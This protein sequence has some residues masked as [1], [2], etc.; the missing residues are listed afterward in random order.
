M[1]RLAFPDAAIFEREES[2][3]TGTSFSNN[4]DDIPIDPALTGIPLDPALLALGNEVQIEQ[5]SLPIVPIDNPPIRYR[6][7]YSQE[8]PTMATPK[9]PRK[10]RKVAREKECGFCRAKGNTNAIP[11]RLLT[12]AECG[13]SGHPTCL[14]IN[15]LG[16]I[17][18]QYDWH[19]IDCKFCEV[20][21][22]KGDESRL[23]FCDVCDRGWHMDCLEP[24]LEEAPSGDWNCPRCPPREYSQMP[25]GQ[26]YPH[27]AD[28]SQP[29]GSELHEAS[30]SMLREPSVASSS[31]S[32]P[33]AYRKRKGK[34]Q[35][36]TTDDSEMDADGDVE[37]DLDVEETPVPVKT[38]GRAKKARS[39]TR[40]RKEPVED[41]IQEPESSRPL[42][43][44]RLRVS[45]PVPPT[46]PRPPMIRLKLPVRTTKGKER[47]EEPDDAKKGM[48]DDLLDVEDRDVTQ[49]NVSNGDKMRFEKSRAEAEAEAERSLHPP[50][51]PSTTL[52]APETPIAGPSTRPL[53]ST[54]IAPPPP[55]PTPGLSASP[56][57]SNPDLTKLNGASTQRIRSIRFG[58]YDIQTWYDA[59]FPEEYANL[60]DGRL[61]LCEFCLKYMKS[62]FVA[63]RHQMKCKMRHPPGDEIYRDGVISIFEVDG[64]KNKIYCQN[65][66]LLSKMFLDHKSLFYDVEPFLFY[67]MT[68][69]DESAGSR[70][71]GYFS[72]EKRSPKDYNVS[73]IMTLPVRQRQ[74]WGNLLIDFSYL[75]SKKEHRTGS[76]EK[77]LSALGALGYKNYWTLSLMRYLRDAPENPKLEDIANAT[78]MTTED[79]YATLQQ[80]Q[81]IS[82][83]D[84]TPP[85]RPPP[86][87][88]FRF[89]KGKK[90]G[91]A[92]KH[93]VR[94][95][96]QDTDQGLTKGPFVP[97]R[98]YDITWDPSVV[99][100]Y[101]VK[102][103]GKGY[104]KL[105]PECLK[106]SPFL[107]ARTMKSEGLPE[108]G[109]AAATQSEQLETPVEGSIPDLGDLVD[110][111]G[112][113]D[114]TP[115]AGPSSSRAKS[116][117]TPRTRRA[118]G[119]R[120]T[121]ASVAAASPAL[122]LFDEPIREVETPN[123]RADP[124]EEEEEE[125][126]EAR[127]E[128][129]E[130]EEESVGGSPK[131][132]GREN[133]EE[134]EVV[135]RRSGRHSTILSLS[136]SPSQVSTTGVP[137]PR[138]RPPRKGR[139]TTSN[140]TASHMNGHSKP[141]VVA[142][143][144]VDDMES[145]IADDEALAKKLAMEDGL[146]RRQLRSRS[147]TS[148]EIKVIQQTRSHKRAAP[149]PP[150]SAIPPPRKR[151]RV[152]D[153][154]EPSSLPIP[155]PVGPVRR[156][157]SAANVKKAAVAQTSP[158]TP[159]TPSSQR[160]STRLTNG[161]T[162]IDVTPSP[163]LF[164]T[165]SGAVR[166]VI[167]SPETIRDDE[168]PGDDAGSALPVD[169]DANHVHTNGEDVKYEDMD[170]PLTGTSR[171]S[172][173]SDDT[174][175]V[176]EDQR[177]KGTPVSPVTFD[178]P[179]PL[180]S[181][182]PSGFPPVPGE[183][184]DGDADA[185]GEDDIDAEGE[186]DDGDLD[187][188]AE[189]E[190]DDGDLD[191]EGEVDDGLDGDSEVMMIL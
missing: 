44:V 42:K 52:E 104:F 25:Q 139:T 145:L 185:E 159:A 62:Q 39:S 1:R 82:V 150:P 17:L 167:E 135:P 51:P 134:E 36:I 149:L 117:R 33:A 158:T 112:D 171:Q 155:V 3:E 186:P 41:V 191:A 128:E 132:K 147:N 50:R 100:A 69:V 34:A 12:C 78:S 28:V 79:I 160:R 182:P 178:A 37:L 174:V 141:E 27:F 86:G 189:G 126:K 154:P 103:E 66:C 120:G 29:S 143:S 70:F 184:E 67:V 173:P 4:A 96:T 56:A 116:K 43:S 22:E 105:K 165:R 95:T 80:Q 63:S 170:T 47:E 31:R 164:R 129:E 176:P 57:P 99:E 97:P 38:K 148:Q 83:R 137:K 107:V 81:M 91:F 119:G 18:Y 48:F 55:L 110:G 92:R 9:P 102:W 140:G 166:R 85:S 124:D 84:N 101:M 114:T 75:L 8:E 21:R 130:E 157:A 5:A 14:Q 113:G 146:S 20:C 45:S 30:T 156:R 7:Q 177:M 19:C 169:A 121:P 108:D 90:N 183:D 72:K 40:P 13:R 172:A 68:E 77:P 71:V 11:E 46:P 59:P 187:L 179:G 94:T 136:T 138:I 98:L 131:K 144:E 161:V 23:L 168:G 162:A 2:Y 127:V 49:T 73:C 151:R 64:R 106:W 175:Y 190:P 24:P 89:P 87:K 111:G 60:L 74:G 109:D 123:G 32:A 35:A 6:R 65:L 188:D 15:E 58:Q 152:G 118:V 54:F 26:G 153:S 180:A 53:R 93:L 115:R 10:K 181:V 133:E 16:D 125:E 61:W 142:P 122:N 76:P 163:E 88:S